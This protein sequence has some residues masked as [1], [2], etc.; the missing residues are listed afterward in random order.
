[1]DAVT[2]AG[3]FRNLTP[4]KEN[5]VKTPKQNMPTRKLRWSA[6]TPISRGLSPVPKIIPME[7]MI[8]VAVARSETE[9]NLDMVAM[10]TGKKKRE[11]VACRNRV[12][13]MRG[14]V[15]D[16][17]KPIMLKPVESRAKARILL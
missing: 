6:T 2:S 8:P 15:E 16:R 13:K 10:P 5:V 7:R 12:A 14:R 3:S 1:M 4:R 11:K 9:V 17:A